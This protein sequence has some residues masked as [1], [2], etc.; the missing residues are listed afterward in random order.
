MNLR[1]GPEV[2][3]PVLA[4]KRSIGEVS[5]YD[6]V[7]AVKHVRTTPG[8]AV[9]P[10]PKRP[11][12][13]PPASPPGEPDDGKKQPAVKIGKTAVPTKYE[14]VCYECGYRFTVAGK[15]RTLY[16]AK[17][18]TILN[19]TDYSIDKPHDV[20]IVTAGV[21]TITETG[22]WSGG[23]LSAR[24]VVLRGRHEGGS[25]KAFRR[26]E[27]A[28][29]SVFRLDALEAEDLVVHEGVVIE[30]GETPMRFREVEVRGEVS[31][32]LEASGLVT[33]HARAVFRGVLKT[34]RFVM[35]DG[36]VLEADVEIGA[37]NET[38]S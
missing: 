20:S 6:V 18:R 21:V 23:T 12:P 4:D 29:G 34:K 35:E 38:T 27:L 36:A 25:I 24:D 9:P 16:C 2:E 28:P 30:G 1:R 13:A 15:V 5:G 8:S 3:N 11:P 10:P 31:G 7:R 19:Q 32:R 14:Y 22:V 37:R 33:L 26:L 17:C